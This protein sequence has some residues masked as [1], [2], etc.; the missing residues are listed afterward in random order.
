[1]RR[2]PAALVSLATIA[3]LGLSGCSASAT[4]ADARATGIQV[5]ASTNVYGDIAARIGG[6]FVSV[7]SAIDDPSQDPH[8][9]EA[10]AQLQLSVSKA[11]VVLVNGAGYDTF[12][13]T[14]FKGANNSDATLINTAK[15]SGK[16]LHPRNNEFNEHLWY[17][18]PTMHLLAAQLVATYSKLDPKNAAA[19]TANAATFDA[20]LTKFEADEAAL[21]AA[22]LGTPIAITEPVPLYLLNAAGLKNI[23]PEKFSEAVEEGT[24]V[25]PVVLSQTT[26]LFTGHRVALLAYNE[27]TSSPET[28]KLLAAAR[29]ALIPVV[30]V[31]ETLPFGTDYVDWMTQNLKELKVAL[32]R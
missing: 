8:S 29:T 31:T 17:D 18:M 32:D 19:F 4:D 9:Y 22:H 24:D 28:E 12:M 20:S 1:M 11:D 30:P 21:K 15:V 6:A 10:D 27:Q 16:N 25:S 26:K 3:V 2:T 23:T 14:L 5:V 7:T 13:N